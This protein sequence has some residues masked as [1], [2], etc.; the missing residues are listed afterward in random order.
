MFSG[1]FFALLANIGGVRPPKFIVQNIFVAVASFSATWQ[2]GPGC[3][4]LISE[5]EEMMGCMSDRA[6]VCLIKS[7][8][9]QDVK[10]S[11]IVEDCVIKSYSKVM[12]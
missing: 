6:I 8:L 12:F 1:P 2:Q 7:V 9:G 4:Q 11:Q 3:T 5:F 10:V